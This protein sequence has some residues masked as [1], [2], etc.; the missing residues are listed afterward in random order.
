M[1]PGRFQPVQGPA[2][3]AGFGRH[4]EERVK[5]QAFSS[6]LKVANEDAVLM[7]PRRPYLREAAFLCP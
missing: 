4:N 3:E 5:L 7:N 1:E 2:V 6:I